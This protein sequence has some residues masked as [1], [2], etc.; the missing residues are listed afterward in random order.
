MKIGML[1]LDAAKERSLA[2][3][4]ERAAAYYLDKYGQQ[5]DLCFVHKTALADETTI[6]AIVVQPAATIPPHHFWLG[7]AA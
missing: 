5:P 3:K 4:I 2:E 7:V 6:D 1:W